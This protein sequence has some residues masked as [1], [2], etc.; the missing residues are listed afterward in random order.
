[1]TLRR[2]FEL[3]LAG[4]ACDTCPARE[5]ICV[6]PEPA[7]APSGVRLAVVGESPGRGEVEAGRPFVGASGRLMQRGLRTLQLRRD[8]VHWT[9]AVLC[10]CSPKD[11][12]KAR[13][14]CAKRLRAELATIAAPVVM[15]LGALGLHSALALERKPQILKWRGSVSKLGAAWVL[16]TLHP[17]FVMRAPKWGPVLEVDFARVGRVLANGFEAP[18]DAPHRRFIVPRTIDDLRAA[19]ELL[20]P[21]ATVSFDVETVGLGPTRTAL[22]C[23]GLSDGITTIVIPW[24]R[25]SNG[26]EPFWGFPQRAL[27]LVNASLATRIAVTHNGPAFDHIVAARYGI[28]FRGGWDDTLLAAH[29]MQGHMPKN[30]AHVV[31]ANAALDVPPWKQLEDRGVD[32]ERLWFYNGRDCLYTILAWQALRKEVGA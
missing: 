26:L 12:P 14:A 21:G 20:I 11:L 8:D 23:F 17:S 3:R 25:A 19:L 18:E 28:E 15:P 30:L 32:I 22:V 1:V 10:D 27:D 2:G 6:P 31:T 29:A 16:P 7:T 9:N 5:G 24:S 4:A 13:K